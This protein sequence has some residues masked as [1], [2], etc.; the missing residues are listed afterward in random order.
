[1]V[2]FATHFTNSNK[3]T[4]VNPPPPG[5]GINENEKKYNFI[6]ITNY[7]I[8]NTT[9][10]NIIDSVI[11]K[12]ETIILSTPNNI[13]IDIDIN[14]SIMSSPEIL[15]SAYLNKY[16]V[17]SSQTVESYTD[18]N[19]SELINPNLYNNYSLGN[20][21]SKEGTINFNQD[22]WN[23][24]SLTN[25]IDGNSNAYYIL[26]HELGHILGIGSLWYLKNSRGLDTITNTLFYRGSNA[27]REYN[28]SIT[29]TNP[30]DP[31]N[32]QYIPIEDNGGPGTEGLHPEEG[33]EL[34]VSTN[35]RTLDGVL[36]PGL[37]REIMTG[38]I[39]NN[40]NSLP[41]SSIT[42]GFF[43]DLGYNIDYTNADFFNI[44]YDN[45]MDNDPGD[46]PIKAPER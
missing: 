16:Y 22:I 30:N 42:V 18:P 44:M 31:I 21:I 41:L 29:F 13:F 1:M 37:N 8:H 9:T 24:Y 15:G 20:V 34:G 23:D 2:F 43:H 11:S 12:I 7:E 38:W 3:S 17:I 25:R 28:D 19:N 39:E 26:L 5:G 4:I 46:D 6:N 27:I 36:Y 45:G 10:K 32:F 40:S 35:S 33:V 14:F